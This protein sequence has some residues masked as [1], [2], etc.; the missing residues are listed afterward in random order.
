MGSVSAVTKS[1]FQDGRIA[2][3]PYSALPHL[4]AEGLVRLDMQDKPI[5]PW[6]QILYDR[7][8]RL[9][10]AEMELIRQAQRFAE[11]LIESDLDGQIYA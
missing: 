10:S 7:N 1:V 2:V 9:N 5:R 8:W 11:D 4:Q 6:V 3:I